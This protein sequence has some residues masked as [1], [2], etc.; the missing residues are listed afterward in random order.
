M[1]LD[2]Y[3]K[4]SDV[5][6]QLGS[7]SW[8]HF[9]RLTVCNKLE[10][11]IQGSRFPLLQNRCC[12]EYYSSNEAQMLLKELEEI[13]KGL[14]EVQYPAARYQD[15]DGNPLDERFRYSEEAVFCGG[16][17]YL[18]GVDKRGLIVECVEQKVP[19]RELFSEENIA[20]FD[21]MELAKNDAWRCYAGDKSVILEGLYV[22]APS[23]CVCIVYETVSALRIFGQ[24]IE[25]L[26]VLCEASIRTGNPIVFC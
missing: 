23:G 9:F 17:G 20:H 4:G 1:G 24:I 11:Q 25:K 7:Y 26:R 21:R 10:N 13:E 18:F 8:Y 5:Y 16:N 2:V 12:D 15:K 3:A 22:C 14:A 19:D 6:V